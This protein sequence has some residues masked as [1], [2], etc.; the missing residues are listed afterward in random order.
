M[1]TTITSPATLAARGAR[2]RAELR[3]VV[4]HAAGAASAAPDHELLALEA[5][6]D[7]WS[8]RLA[9]V[10]ARVATAAPATRP[11]QAV[12]AAAG[13]ATPPVLESL[14]IDRGL[15]RLSGRDLPLTRRHTEIVVLLG[16]RRTAMTTE[17]LA[18]ALYGE[19]GR[20]GTVR[21]ELFRLRKLMGPWLNAGRDGL[22]LSIDADFLTVQAHLRAGDPRRA[23]EQYPGPLLPRSEAPGVVELREELDAWVR[24]AV[25]ATE[26]RE[27]LWAWL[28][29][30]SGRDDRPGLKR[31][32]A[33]LPFDDPRRALAASRLGQ[34]RATLR[35]VR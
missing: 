25:I 7:A 35:I 13:H 34:L 20:P 3:D 33:D 12:P 9:A 4:A 23:A 22:T 15:L 28:E 2:A 32:L 27:A 17:E 18:L 31:F 10:R 1:T 16:A 11:L 8:R 29:S 5:Q 21:T 19:R 26:D 24:R 14:D 6:L 30:S